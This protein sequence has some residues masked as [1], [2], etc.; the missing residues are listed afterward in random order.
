MGSSTSKLKVGTKVLLKGEWLDYRQES[1][2][3]V[4][5]KQGS[6][7]TLVNEAGHRLRGY[8]DEKELIIDN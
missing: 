3:F 2:L 8:F 5:S 4:D 1:K 6:K 7:V